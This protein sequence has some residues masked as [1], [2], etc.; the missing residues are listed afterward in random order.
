M[1]RPGDDMTSPIETPTA[2]GPSGATG[3][4]ALRAAGLSAGYHQV[5]VVHD[6]DLEVRR[7]EMVA[8]FGPNGAG[9][10][11]TLLALAGEV[12]TLSGVVEYFGTPERRPLHQRAQDG[13]GLLTEDRAVFMT[14]TARDNL[15]LGR[16]SVESA[17][18]FFPELEAHLDRRTSL[19]SGGQQQMLALA[20]I[21]AG[22]PRIVLADELSLGLAPMVVE[23]LLLALRAAADQGAAVL[24]V[25]QHVRLALQ[26]V[27]RAYVLA[28]G[29]VA[30]AA[31]AARLRDHPD[32]VTDLY[33]AQAATT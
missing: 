14:L 27:D 18:G 16:G 31:P 8:L 26:H 17:L 29:R 9:K 33:L 10:T 19:L 13:L 30:L 2:Q 20:R 22:G 28:R 12:A 7:G 24:L 15:R 5:P 3:A 21:L 4:P 32:R 1:G 23:R 11:T 25:E 6:L